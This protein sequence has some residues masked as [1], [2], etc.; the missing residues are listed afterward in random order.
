MY[1][2]YLISPHGTELIGRSNDRSVA[3]KI[4][5]EQDSKWEV[6]CMWTTELTEKEKEEVSYYD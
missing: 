2:V 5:S 3:E 1:F 6:G 4:K